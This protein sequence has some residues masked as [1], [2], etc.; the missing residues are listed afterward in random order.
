[1]HCYVE[2]YKIIATP[3]NSKK[4]TEFHIKMEKLLLE[5]E[6]PKEPKNL[7]SHLWRFPKKPKKWNGSQQP[8]LGPS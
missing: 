4:F 5:N 3:M 8:W 1:M 6:K 2:C 7:I